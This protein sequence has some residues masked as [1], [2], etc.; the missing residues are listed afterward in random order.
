MKAYLIREF[1]Y[2]NMCS[3]REDP[4][5]EKVCGVALE[6]EFA[7]RYISGRRDTTDHYEGGPFRSGDFF[8][9]EDY[10]QW[11]IEEIDLL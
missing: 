4:I 11:E 6:R 1:N 3:F 7:E 10:P 2:D 9:R 8:A 5:T